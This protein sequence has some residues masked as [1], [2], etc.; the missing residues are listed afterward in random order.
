MV[1]FCN[2]FIFGA[3]PYE[4]HG[5]VRSYTSIHIRSAPVCESKITVYGTSQ[6][7]YVF[8]AAGHLQSIT[9]C[10]IFFL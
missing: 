8:F 4:K 10:D 7:H 1:L 2:G 5:T 6:A 3:V 9:F